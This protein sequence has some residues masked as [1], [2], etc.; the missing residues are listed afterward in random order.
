MGGAVGVTMG[1]MMLR[2]GGPLRP[3]GRR[4]TTLFHHDHRPAKHV[5]SPTKA[6][7]TGHRS[8][9]TNLTRYAW[10]SIAA[11]IVNI[12]L[13]GGAYLIT[14]SVGL[15]SI[16]A[17]GLVNLF[18]AVVALI[19]LHLASMP[20]DDKHQ[21]GRAKAE[22]FSAAIESTLICIAGASILFTAV[23]HL[24]NPPELE[25]I[26]IGLV[27]TVIAAISNGTVGWILLSAGRR[28][29]SMTLI[30]DGRHLITDLITSF[31]VVIGLVA[32]TLTG[33]ARLDAIIAVIVSLNIIVTGLKL[34]TSSSRG[35]LDGAVPADVH[36][37][38][39]EMFEELTTED[40]SY[41]G[42]RTREA[43]R[44]TFVS[45]H[46]VVPAEWPVRQGY[47]V[48]A[49]VEQAVREVITTPVDV[50]MRLE[51]RGVQCSYVLR[52]GPDVISAFGH[53]GPRPR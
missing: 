23:R 12:S 6:P 44:L 53:H 38:L 39:V 19:A 29:R 8:S 13:K 2:P 28:Y 34:L 1:L 25:R 37:H 49:P 11:A 16:A 3:P 24:V 36:A 17:E 45:V 15:L 30:T 33:W 7:D 52:Y 22:Y 10:L 21:Y 42:L 31:G 18:A 26:G 43:G 47:A 14:G 46:I 35:L 50:V 9:R 32:V 41:H 27:V 51:P 4:L 5:E 48:L 40:I 20:P